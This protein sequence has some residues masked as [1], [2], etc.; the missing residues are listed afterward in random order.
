MFTMFAMHERCEK[1]D[2]QD[3]YQLYF[4]P[5]DMKIRNDTQGIGRSTN[6]TRE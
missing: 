1:F 6:R 5:G 3:M 4:E 2:Q